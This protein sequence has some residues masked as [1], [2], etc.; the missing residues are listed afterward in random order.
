MFNAIFFILNQET[1]LSL[2]V[3][4]SFLFILLARSTRVKKNLFSFFYCTAWKK[5]WWMKRKLLP[6][7]LSILV[8]FW[9][10]LSLLYGS[11]TWLVPSPCFIVHCNTFLQKCLEVIHRQLP[12]SRPGV[13][14]YFSFSDMGSD[15]KAWK[16]VSN[17]FFKRT[18][19]RIFNWFLGGGD[20][21]A[22]PND[23]LEDSKPLANIL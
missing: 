16:V 2:L 5:L 17:Y 21:R 15:E 22:S 3:C 19:P 10:F 6:S 7:P 1:V 12:S 9:T 20:V 4:V 14:Q 13:T 11:M 18:L 8:I 23:A